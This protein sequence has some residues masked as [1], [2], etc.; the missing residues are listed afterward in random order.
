M[1]ACEEDDDCR[2]DEGYR[3]TTASEFGD[4]SE[5]E[6]LGR[7]SQ[8]F[9]SIPAVQRPGPMSLPDGGVAGGSADDTDAG[10]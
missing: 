4:G 10:D 9:C 1:Y 2:N 6:I 3:C 7:K 8:G 5:A